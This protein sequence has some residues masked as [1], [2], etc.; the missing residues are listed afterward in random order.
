[1]KTFVRNL[2]LK[3]KI[4]SIVWIS[5][6]L[7]LAAALF[8]LHQ[9]SASYN[10]MLYQTTA[11]SLSASSAEIARN[12]NDINTMMDL[13]LADAT[14]QNSLSTLK[15]SDQLQDINTAYSSAYTTLTEYY[16]TFRQNYMEYMSLYQDTF[17]IHTHI[18][19][20]HSVPEEV[21][22]D[23]LARSR[24]ARGATVW[25]TD[26]SMEYGIFA[27]KS[28]RRTE[29]L[30]LDDLGTLI[31]CLDPDALIGSVGQTDPLYDS[32]NYLLYNA[33]GPIYA[34]ASIPEAAAS[35]LGR[36]FGEP[37]GRLSA[38]SQDYFYVRGVIPDF[39]WSYICI[40]P[41][42]EI[43]GAIRLATAFCLAVMA[44]AAVITAVLSSS[45]ITSIT[46]H[47]DNLLLKF[48][49]FGDGNQTPPDVGYDYSSRADELGMLHQQF[50][51]MVEEVNQLIRTNYLHEI[52][53]KE[54]QLKAL[55]NQMNPHFLYN[56]LESINWR[57]KI[58]GAKDISSMAEALGTLLRITL[59]QKNTQV[60]LRRE[61]EL[62]QCYM[63]IQKY[64]YE[65]RLNYQVDV[66]ERLMR[67]WVLK[68]T[69]QPLVENAI[70][71]GLEENTEG[72]LIQILAETDPEERTLY[73][74]VKNNGS[75]FEEDLLKKLDSHEIQPHGFGIGLLNIASRMQLTYGEGYGLT[76]Y[77][78]D[79][80]AVAKLTYPLQFTLPAS[81]P[82]ASA[83]EP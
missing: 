10:K 15:D 16:F 8:S 9:T 50:D 35:D 53:I 6:F 14:I 3:Y 57:A 12:L 31:V 11:V 71:Y 38:G 48:R 64:R 13:F 54:A 22:D 65:D 17:T 21:M 47:F 32:A 18:S 70:R 79:D 61:L 34:S 74:Y 19:L 23:L 45:L 5:M 25:V 82:E 62:V 66:P 52:L 80:V 60:P 43:A 26:Y 46:R 37:Y 78:E 42:G 40:I 39:N 28:L 55:E 30:R 27:V 44:A 41:Y 69:L 24:E 33:S 2:S 75:S 76:L 7:L 29:Y 81:P 63:T 73:L 83:A 77:N 51:L 49:R 56:T 36:I 68:L 20:R 1:M 58:A 72:C 67:C 59:D 4:Q